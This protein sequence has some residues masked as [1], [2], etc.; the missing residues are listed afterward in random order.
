MS[1][2]LEDPKVAALVNKEVTKAVA[3]ERKRTT[4]IMKALAG[5][6]KEATVAVKNPVPF[7]TSDAA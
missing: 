1:K 3:A 5:E 6:L 7:D 2:L 4:D